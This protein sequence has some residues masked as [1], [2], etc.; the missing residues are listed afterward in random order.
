MLYE[1]RHDTRYTYSQPVALGHNF[2]H[3]QLR[4]CPGQQIKEMSL[5]ITPEPAVRTER[6]DYFG[7]PVTHFTLQQRHRE[8]TV[9][10]RATVEV[11][12]K[13][14]VALAAST[15]WE[16]IQ[17]LLSDDL[18]QQGLD[19]YQYT[20]DSPLASGSR[21]LRDYA[22]PGFKPGRPIFEAVMEL[23]TRIFKDFKYDPTTTTVSTPTAQV[24][25]QRSGVCQDFA[26]LMIACLRAWGLPARY[27]SGYLRTLPP[28]GKQR[29]VGADASHAWVGVYC[30]KLGWLDFDPTNNKVVG[31][32]HITL[33]WGR[34]YGDVSPVRGLILGGGKHK[35]KVEVDVAAVS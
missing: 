1:L 18:T 13:Q 12:S 5:T 4:D 34:D 32:H 29:L 9:S 27:V 35:I 28:P 10:S 31:D 11:E 26:H 3:M 14:P 16:D 23:T 24:F 33:A 7:N 2:L 21:S 8:M 19:A 17:R 15:P 6:S 20:F 22:E 30:P 25:E